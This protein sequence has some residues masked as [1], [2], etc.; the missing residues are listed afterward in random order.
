MEMIFIFGAKYLPLVIAGG[1]VVYFLYASCHKKSRMLFYG[2]VAMPLAFVFGKIAGILVH[3]QRPFV[4]LDVQPLVAHVADNGFP[5]E[6]TLYALIIAGVI[7]SVQR[8]FGLVLLLTAGG[9]GMARILSLIHN[10]VDIL[11]SV[12]VAGIV[13]FVVWSIPSSITQKTCRRVETYCATIHK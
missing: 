9:V 8:K 6:H 12:V 2:A 5:S 1:A 13:F 7:F 11:G 3:T 10:P 4:T